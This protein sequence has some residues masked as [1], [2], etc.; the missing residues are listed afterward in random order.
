VAGE[1]LK[2]SAGIFC[3]QLVQELSGVC[4]WLVVVC[5]PVQFRFQGAATRPALS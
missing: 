3:E 5:T 2:K 1:T 4:R